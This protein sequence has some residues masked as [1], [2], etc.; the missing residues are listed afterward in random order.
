[1]ALD[2]GVQVEQSQTPAQGE[3]YAMVKIGQPNQGR[4]GEGILA[5]LPSGPGTLGRGGAAAQAPLQGV[6]GST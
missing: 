1:M 3:S 2:P 4:I 5:P 6:Q